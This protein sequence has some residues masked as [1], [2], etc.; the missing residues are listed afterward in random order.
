MR[1]GIPHRGEAQSCDG[2]SLRHEHRFVD[3]ARLEAAGQIDPGRIRY[4]PAVLKPAKLPL[5]PSDDNPLACRRIPD[6]QDIAGIFGV[7]DSVRDMPPIAQGMIEGRLTNHE[8]ASYQPFDGLT[9][10]R[11]Y[12]HVGPH[13]ARL[14]GHVELP[15]DI[16]QREPLAHEKTVAE[17]RLGARVVGCGGNVEV[18][19][20]PLAA[21]IHDVEQDRAVARS[22]VLRF[23]QVE[24]GRKLDAARCIERRVVDV[25]D[26]PVGAVLRIHLEM[27]SPRK[28]FIGAGEAPRP[29][30]EHV[31]P[32][33]HIEADSFRARGRR[34]QQDQESNK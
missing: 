21:A 12:R 32:D 13:Q 7:H 27:D 3:P 22:D 28:P 2:R 31:L 10:V 26:D 17:I 9:T 4:H 18:P 23:Q 20:Y 24:V 16:E 19:E 8:V 30:A 1:D 33:F 15:P 11:G 6:G 29:A 14:L 5:I 34:T 25:A